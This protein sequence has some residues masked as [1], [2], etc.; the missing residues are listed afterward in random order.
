M[1]KLLLVLALLLLPTAAWAQCSGVF[2]SGTVCGN[3]SL[4]AA[5]PRAIPNPGTIGLG[6]R[7]ITGD[8]TVTS[9]DQTLVCNRNPAA[10]TTI[11]LPAVAVRGGVALYYMDWSGL[12]GDT[13]FLPD[14]AE[15]IMGLANWKVVSGGVAGSG[16]A[17]LLVPSSTL[18]GWVV[19]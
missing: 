15:T 8:T 5:P 3:N 4:S 14:G 9:T 13:T 12:C 18:S 1:K 19:Q 17:V 16:G 2:P 6:L 7:V 11:T 10:P